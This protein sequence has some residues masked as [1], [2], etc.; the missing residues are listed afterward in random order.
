MDYYYDNIDTSNIS[1]IP[2]R[3]K[4][5]NISIPVDKQYLNSAKLQNLD[6]DIFSKTD[7]D[8]TT[9]APPILY[10][11]E[12]VLKKCIKIKPDN[13]HNI[14]VKSAE[15][16][17]DD[18]ELQKALVELTEQEAIIIQTKKDAIPI[19]KE[20][21]KSVLKN[22]DK[23]NVIVLDI[24]PQMN[25]GMQKSNTLISR[26]YSETNDIPA[27]NLITLRPDELRTKAIR[28]DELSSEWKQGS[29][30]AKQIERNIKNVEIISMDKVREIL[31]GIKGLSSDEILKMYTIRDLAS[32]MKTMNTNIIASQKKKGYIGGL[33][34]QLETIAK[35]K[36][37][38]T[39]VIPDDCSLS[40]SSMLCDSVKIFDNFIKDNPDKKIHVIF[41]P[42]ILGDIA[43][44]AFDTFMDKDTPVNNMYLRQVNAIKSDG[45]ESYPGVKNAFE[46]VKNSENITFEVTPNA[47]KAK[48]FSDTDYFKN[49]KDQKLKS[50]LTYII[51]GGL[52]SAGAQFG[53]FGNCGTLVITPTEE[54][55]L[56]GRT[57]AG[58]I[59][60]NSVGYMEIVGHQA[61]V[62]NDEVDDKGK[63]VFT[64]GTGKGYTRYCEWEGLAHPEK[65]ED[66][67]PITID[68]KGNISIKK[69]E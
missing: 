25:N 47:Q 33:I 46:R 35:D 32:V 51:Q 65:A 14:A 26:W 13:I 11:L 60:T 54:Y 50:K 44:N 43:Q 38:L 22:E 55:E 45:T 28:P 61:G 49:I 37:E 17:T 4:N 27:E 7:T 29:P 10:N 64:K 39:V 34:T 23:N 59:P 31:D 1:N 48:H 53:G 69:T 52:D 56:D 36:N 63:G 6:T 42:L 8:N 12:E 57:Y 2:I 58:K 40:G 21:F 19:I 62:L 20:Q 15:I 30:I 24:N 66:R 18:K 3:N 67:L 9:F 41:S 16:V 68:S 5:I